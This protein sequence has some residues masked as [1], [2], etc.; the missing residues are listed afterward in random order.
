MHSRG[1]S[2]VQ[3]AF[4]LLALALLA[5][6]CMPLRYVTQAAAGQSDLINRRVEIDTL[7]RGGHLTARTRRLLAEVAVIKAFGERHGLTATR[8]YTTY[9]NVQRPAVVW[10][11]SA[12]EPLR[13]R[14]R[15]WSFPVTGSIT[16]LGWFHRPEAERFASDLREEGWDVDLRGAGAYS[17]LGWFEDPVLSTMIVRGDAALG[18]LA[19]VIL[20]ESLHATFY[21]RAQSTLNESVASFVGN[22]LA[23]SFLDEAVG[24]DSVEKKSYEELEALAEARGAIMREGY[25]ELEKLYAGSLPPSAKLAEKA[26]VTE[27]L[28]A[29]TH[30]KRAVNNATLVQYATYGS[31]SDELARL[32]ELCGGS[33]P[34]FLRTLERWRPRFEAAADHEDPGKL[35]RPLLPEGCSR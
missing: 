27:R 31:G 29:R 11:V 26:R 30:E 9:V 14:S 33:W 21:V 20:H 7:V 22:H 12:C 15:T 8:N 25:K 16:Y 4:L 32:L 2:P 28:R 17:T 35:L 1:E 6:G 34:R 24:A 5:I 23:G 10:V 13:F 3:R 18:E 19:D